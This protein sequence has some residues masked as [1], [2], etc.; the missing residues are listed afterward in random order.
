MPTLFHRLANTFVLSLTLM[1]STLSAPAFAAQPDEPHDYSA[2]HPLRIGMLL[3]DGF[4]MLDVFGPLEMF[5]ML[6]DKVQMVTVGMQPGLVRPRNGPAVQIEQAMANSGQFDLFIIPGGIGTRTEV[7]NPALLSALKVVSE[8]TPK[9]ASVC[10]GAA[11]LARTG[12]LDGFEATTNKLAFDWVAS[13]GPNVD[14]IE[15]ARWVDAGKFA[16]SSG[17]SA[18][19]DLAL[20]LI[21]QYFGRATAEDVAQRTEYVWNDDPHNDPFARKQAPL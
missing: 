20:A 2:E 18:G 21:E 4:E 14:W 15:E 19:T 11:L 7:N 3:F 9:V 17:V 5:G 10:T 16:S 1:M 6:G 8:A 12:L 13:Q